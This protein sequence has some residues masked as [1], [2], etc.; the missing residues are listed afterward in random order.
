MA[1][2][3]SSHLP[4]STTQGVN[5]HPCEGWALLEPQLRISRSTVRTTLPTTYYLAFNTLSSTTTHTP[6]MSWN[7]G[8][9]GA[10]TTS[11]FVRSHKEN[12]VKTPCFVD[13]ALLFIHPDHHLTN[14]HYLWAKILTS[15]H[16]RIVLSPC[17]SSNPPSHFSHS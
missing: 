9:R 8:A 12:A 5:L 4:Q 17:R 11:A 14:L 7:M 10:I 6:P 1:L 2:L 16:P 3:G 13:R 15:P